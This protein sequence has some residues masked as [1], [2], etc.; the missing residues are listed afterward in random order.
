MDHP[1]QGIGKI[2]AL[3]NRQTMSLPCFLMVFDLQILSIQQFHDNEHDILLF[4]L[5]DPR[6]H[7]TN[8]NQNH[9]AD[10]SRPITAKLFLNNIC[11]SFRLPSIIL[12]KITNQN[13]SIQPDHDD[14]NIRFAASSTTALFMSSKLTLHPDFGTIPFNFFNDPLTGIMIILS[15]SIKQFN[16]SPA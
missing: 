2:K 12:R 16:R 7:P 8:L 14:F 15:S 11:R 3:C 6:Q 9:T 10:K 1:Y 4:H 13:I 5:V